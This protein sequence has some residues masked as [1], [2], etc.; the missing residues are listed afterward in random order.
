MSQIRQW[1]DLYGWI[2][3]KR[4]ERDGICFYGSYGGYVFNLIQRKGCKEIKIYLG[5]LTKEQQ[6]SVVLDLDNKKQA[7]RIW[8]TDIANNLLTIKLREVL[9]PVPA[10]IIEDIL[11]SLTG[12]FYDMK[13]QD[14]NHCSLCG[15][16]GS[17]N[18]AS[19]EGIITPLCQGCYGHLEKNM[20]PEFKE[21]ADQGTE[22]AAAQDKAGGKYKWFSKGYLKHRWSKESYWRGIG[23]AVIAGIISLILIEL[24][25]QK[26]MEIAVIKLQNSKQEDFEA[27]TRYTRFLNILLSIGVYMGYKLFKGKRSRIVP[28]MLMGLTFGLAMINAPVMSIY[29]TMRY[30]TGPMDLGR[31]LGFIKNYIVEFYIFGPHRAIIWRIILTQTLIAFI[32]LIPCFFDYMGWWQR[33]IGKGKNK[34]LVS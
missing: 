22:S 30:I 10:S 21:R 20:V 32:G 9:R 23:G 19:F 17:H 24:S 2:N 13:M 11:K 6:Q 18:M 26:I 8:R 3:Y 7:L 4:S 1:L 16:Y 27:L 15:D 29:H 31:A 5:G 33:I 34:G 12:L 28:F 25:F 14:K